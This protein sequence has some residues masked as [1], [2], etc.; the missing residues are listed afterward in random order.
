LIEVEAINERNKVMAAQ[1]NKISEMK[2]EMLETIG[3]GES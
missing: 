1:Q 3:K 2:A